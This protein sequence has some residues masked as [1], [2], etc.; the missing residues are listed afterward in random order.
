MPGVA[1]LPAFSYAVVRKEPLP[2]PTP[3]ARRKKFTRSPGERF[4]TLPS[5]LRKA[6]S[7]SKYSIEGSQDIP[8]DGG[9]SIQ[10]FDD[11]EEYLRPPVR[12]QPVTES[13]QALNN[14]DLGGKAA[15]MIQEELEQER[16]KPRPQA[17]RR[18][19]KRTRDDASVDKDAD[20]FINGFGGRSVSNTFL[21]PHEDVSITFK[22]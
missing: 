6:R 14:L 3:P 13:E 1:F 16:Q 2:K 10:Y 20:S 12:D 18:Q 17:P 15:A 5:I 19:K 8:Q 22:L 7:R 4:A 21:Q 11:D 9:S